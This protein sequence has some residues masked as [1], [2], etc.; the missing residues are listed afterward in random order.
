MNTGI[1]L[2][3]IAII[4]FLVLM[5]M[6]IKQLLK[7]LAI[8]LTMF[9]IFAGYIYVKNGSL[10]KDLKGYLQEGKIAIEQLHQAYSNIT[11]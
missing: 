2:T 6:F 5:Y 7:L 1:L 10:P 4:S 3:V 8:I 11:H 9:I